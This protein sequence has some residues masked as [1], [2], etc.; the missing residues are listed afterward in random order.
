MSDYQDT[1]FVF[2]PNENIRVLDTGKTFVYLV[3]IDCENTKDF[4]T[5]S[6]NNDGVYCGNDIL[7]VILHSH[8]PTETVPMEEAIESITFNEN[9]KE[10]TNDKSLI[11][12]VLLGWSESSYYYNG[13]QPWICE[14]NNLTEHGR[15]LYFSLKKLHNDKE[16]KILTFNHIK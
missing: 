3:A 15:R 10:E 1:G 6:I 5:I 11:S 14:F 8:A 9:A 4:S 7:D 13:T 2:F 16:I 12:S